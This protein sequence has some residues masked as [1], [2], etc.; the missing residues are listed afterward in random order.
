MMGAWHL[1]KRLSAPPGLSLCLGIPVMILNK[2]DLLPY[3]D[4]DVAKY[5]ASILQLPFWKFPP[6][7]APVLMAGMFGCGRMRRPIG[8][9]QVRDSALGPTSANIAP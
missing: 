9:A 6:A 2:I 4:F 7:A 1:A 8:E 5:A 3:V